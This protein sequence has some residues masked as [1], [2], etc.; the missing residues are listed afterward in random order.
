MVMS[1]SVTGAGIAQDS[2]V[3]NLMVV[4]EQEATGL[5]LVRYAMMIDMSVVERARAGDN[6]VEKLCLNVSS[7]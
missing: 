1:F 4:P 5:S 3:A 6:M 7:E 2:G